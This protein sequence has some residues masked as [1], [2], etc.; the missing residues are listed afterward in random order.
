MLVNM[1]YRLII[2]GESLGV[3]LNSKVNSKSYFGNLRDKFS[4]IKARQ[5][6]VP[7]FHNFDF[8]V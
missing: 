4:Y 2:E 8:R 1:A 6:V 3:E 5:L 7:K